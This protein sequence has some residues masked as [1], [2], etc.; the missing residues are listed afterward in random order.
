MVIKFG[1]E[2]GAENFRNLEERAKYNF[3]PIPEVKI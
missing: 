3:G 2:Y 1:G